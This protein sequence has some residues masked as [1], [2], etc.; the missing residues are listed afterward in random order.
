M[1]PRIIHPNSK[2][3]AAVIIIFEVQDMSLWCLGL[4]VFRSETWGHDGGCYGDGKVAGEGR[5]MITSRH[6]TRLAF[7]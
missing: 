6:L 3:T 1:E 4:G 2:G 7:M 5:G